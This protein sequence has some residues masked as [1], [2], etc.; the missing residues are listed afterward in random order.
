MLNYSI[1]L[2]Y[3]TLSQGAAEL[4]KYLLS[5]YG[6]N[7]FALLVDEGGKSFASLIGYT[8]KP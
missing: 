1:I 6:K 4:A 7:G 2:Q 5:T 8:K 3:L